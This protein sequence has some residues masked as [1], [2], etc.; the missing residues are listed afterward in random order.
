MFAEPTCDLV[1]QFTISWLFDYKVIV[2]DFIDASTILR[3]QVDFSVDSHPCS[4]LASAIA[5]YILRIVYKFYFSVLLTQISW[6]DIHCKINGLRVPWAK[7]FTVRCCIYKKKLAAEYPI[8]AFQ[9]IVVVASLT[10]VSETFLSKKL[11]L[12]WRS[13]ISHILLQ[14]VRF[15]FFL[16]FKIKNILERLCI[17]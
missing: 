13:K 17:P 1:K 16:H 5:Q 2:L 6:L 7:K 8:R 14:A 12:D 15:W 9:Q 10:Q 3:V 11:I 4:S